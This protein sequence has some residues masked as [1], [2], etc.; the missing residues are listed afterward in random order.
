VNESLNG[1]LVLDLSRLLPGPYC[2]M[3]LAD[4][5]A[6]V[7]AIEDRRFE[8]GHMQ[9]LRHINRNKEHMTLNLKT[10]KGKEIFFA[11]A[12]KADIILDGFRPGVTDRLGVGYD[13]VRALN[14]RLI[15]CAVTGY[16]QTG[17]MKDMA[18]HDVNYLGHG[19]ALSVIGPQ[20]NPPCIP[21]IQIADILGG[22][23][24][25]IGILLALHFRE[26]TGKGQYIDI[27][28]TDAVMAALPVSAG[29]R[30][31]F[32]M[33]PERG[34]TLLSHRYACY[35][36][37]RTADGKYITLGALEPQFWE[38]VCRFFE[39]PEFIPLQF[40]DGHR[41]MLID[42]FQK[43][44]LTKTRNEWTEAFKEHDACLGKVLDLEEALTGNYATERQMVVQ[45]EQSGDGPVSLLGIPVKLA[46]SRGTIRSAPPKFGE[47]T[48][49]I[50]K[51]LGFSDQQIRQF[52]KEGVV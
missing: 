33:I 35:N 18:G 49:S 26:K 7:I 48:R 13:A 9:I 28:I 19:G 46:E 40:D 45:L 32:G 47:N 5:G 41:Q 43:A 14:P 38:V 36:I 52:E 1:C 22:L 24:A 20:N 42:F 31:L 44:F 39:K 10:E 21:G 37:Y 30:W 50:L 8:A 12:Q 4:H 27:S 2:S 17:S 51:E 3:I 23:N 29:M 16:G 25:A 11:L 15:Y 34:N 6:R